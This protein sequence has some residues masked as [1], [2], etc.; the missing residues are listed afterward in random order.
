MNRLLR[1]IAALAIVLLAFAGLPSH[2]Q[3]LRVMSFNIRLPIA[4]DGANR[5]EQR[6][7]L[8][9]RTLREQHPDIIGTQEL[10]RPQGD[11]IV[12]RLPQYAWFGRDRRGGHDDEHMGVFYR[13][14]RLRVVESGDFWLSDTP[15]VPGSISWGHPYPRMVTWA[16]FERSSDRRR[17]Y[18]F[19][20][21]L[22]Y[23]DEDDDARERGARLIASRLAL[24][25]AGTPVIVTGDFN[26]APDSHTHAL[27]AAALTDA[28]DSA[29]LR[30]GPQAT[31][32]D[33]TGKPDHRI[34]WILY[35]GMRPLSVHTITSHQ[36]GRYPSDHFPVVAEFDFPPRR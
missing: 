13:K 18:L 20:T 24:L 21:H 23:R 5:W 7:A 27:L 10:H 36:G 16:L 8:I 22:P 17:F 2:A 28:W 31:F 29:P 34:D 4:A 6:K 15:E 19:N 14:D 32:H 11:D 3:N 25:P 35:R 12:R 1:R 33:F 26:T 30:T 9:A